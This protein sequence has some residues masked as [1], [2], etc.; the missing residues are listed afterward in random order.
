MTP[1][2]PTVECLY[3]AANYLGESP[4]W[5]VTEQELYWINCEREPTLF[6]LDPASGALRQWPLPERIGGVYLDASDRLYVALASGIY[7]F[8]PETSALDLIAANP[9]PDTVM[10]HEG[11]CDRQGRLWIGSL[12]KR[13]VSHGETGGAYIYRLDGDTLVPQISDISVANGLAWSPDG[14]RMYH[15]DTLASRVWVHDY[16]TATGAIANPR[17]LFA[18]TPEEGGLDGAA[19]D[20]EGGYWTALFKGGCLR[21]YTPEGV[22]DREIAL[23]ISQ[24][25]MPAFGGPDLTT[26]FVT[27][28]RHGKSAEDVE[29]E[30]GLG[31]L[32]TI[33]G[34]AQGL[35]EPR[36]KLEPRAR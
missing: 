36:L 14:S 20:A 34:L 3:R 21:R 6:R 24:P 4:L 1:E 12:S 5:S 31:D 29:R 16:D 8:D 18:I 27:T 33:A 30:P 10:L 9:H 26:L 17:V 25:T 2:T 35:P 19:V 7:G 11:K 15:T 23:P 13:L 22:L 32:Y 28:T